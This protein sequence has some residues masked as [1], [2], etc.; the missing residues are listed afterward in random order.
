MEIALNFIYIAI[1]L[2][3]QY[4][5]KMYKVW[6]IFAKQGV[7][8]MSN[9]QFTINLNE[10]SQLNV[11]L[12][13]VSESRYETDWNSIMHSHPFTELF[14]VVKGR[15]QFF[16]ENKVFDV[17]E[18]DLIIV[19][20]N[21]RHTESSKDMEPLE[22]IVLGVDD[23]SILAQDRGGGE[24][25]SLHNYSDYKSDVLFYLKTLLKEVQGRSE[26][27]ELISKNLLEILLINIIRKTEAKLSVT[28]NRVLVSNCKY[29]KEYIEEHFKE[30]L[31]LEDLCRVSYMNKYYL[32]HSF[33]KYCGMTPIQYIIHLR[34]KMACNLLLN[35]DYSIAHIAS[36]IGMSSQSYFA[37]TFKKEFGISP[38]MYRK[39][40]RGENEESS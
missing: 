35:S 34:L 3:I 28:E 38:L 18:D 24:Y 2:K 12:R 20:A 21:V 40:T 19:N 14:Y 29:V 36:F 32:V 17:K 22:Y 33:K 39:R 1:V 5:N 6:K 11:T 23:I 27:Y 10:S 4:N 13:Y 26:Y 9:R 25:Y 15:G 7:I 16:I 8:L 31:S 37:Q 30:E